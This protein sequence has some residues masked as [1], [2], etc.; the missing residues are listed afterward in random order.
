MSAK[1]EFLHRVVLPK[2]FFAIREPLNSE[3]WPFQSVSDDEIVQ[4]GGVFLPYPVLLVD[5]AFFHL[6]AERDVFFGHGGER[7]RPAEGLSQEL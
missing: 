5:E 4:E 7:W 1:D 6:I 2:R 3:G